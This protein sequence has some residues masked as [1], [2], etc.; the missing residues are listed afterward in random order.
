MALIRAAELA[1]VR[2]QAP[3]LDSAE[4]FFNLFGLAT[5]EKTKDRLWLRGT[6]PEQYLIAVQ[7]G[8][9]RLLATA[10]EVRELSD[11]HKAAREIDGASDV[12]AL[13]EPGGGHRVTAK[14]T[15]GNEIELVHGIART[16]SLSV[17]KRFLNSALE[18]ERRT[19]AIV[20]PSGPSRVL[21][22]GHTVIKSPDVGRLVDW[23]RNSLGLIES[24]DVPHPRGDGLLMSFLRLN[25][26]QAFVDHHTLQIL[27]GP[28]NMLHHVSFEV[29]DIDD[30]HCGH[31]VLAKAGYRHVWGIGRHMQGSQIFDYWL[32]PFG[33]M[34]EHWTDTDML[35]ADMAKGVTRFEDMGS[36]WG[37][38]IPH[39][40]IEQAT[41]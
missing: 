14:D 28:P 41:R 25:Q 15:D 11:L 7:R 2:M 9:R 40:F 31:D 21:R 13:T 24:D 23:Y 10:Y 6:G 3:D 33:V 39:A 22:I 38:D 19:N 36:G 17:P 35:N 16:E 20:R 18:R 4:K 12:Q 32:D 5:R 8:E 1:F 26:G 34:Y 37:P 29:Q 30:L 27:H